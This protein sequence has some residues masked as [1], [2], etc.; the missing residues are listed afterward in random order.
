[1]TSE[2]GYDGQ[3]MYLMAFDPLIRRFTN[4]VAE[5]RRILDD[6][7]YRYGR[8]GFSALTR[9]LSAGAA[10]RY[11]AVMVWLTVLAHLPLAMA[12]AW[13][14]LGSARSPFAALSY[15]A[16]P[17]FAASVAFALPE[18]LAAAGLIAGIAAWQR[19]R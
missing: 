10:E 4:D 9:A 15:L 1:V 8:I 19:E 17:S 14:A 11:P 13:L 12:F 18:A 5:Y 7:P 2:A 6:P 16:I 3:F